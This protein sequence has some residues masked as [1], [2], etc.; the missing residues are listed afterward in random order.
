MHHVNDNEVVIPNQKYRKITSN[1]KKGILA[2]HS[3]INSDNCYINTEV[4]YKSKRN[5]YN[6]SKRTSN[7]LVHNSNSTMGNKKY[8]NN[9][10]K[11]N[12][13]CSQIKAAII[14]K[15]TYLRNT[16]NGNNNNICKKN[17]YLFLHLN[18]DNDLT[19]STA[20]SKRITN[21]NVQ[22]NK[23][24]SI[25]KSNIGE[26]DN[27]IKINSNLPVIKSLRRNF[28]Q[29]FYNSIDLFKNTS[30]HFHSKKRNKETKEYELRDN[31]AKS[32]EKHNNE[33]E[34]N[35][36]LSF[37]MN[38]SNISLTYSEDTETK[39]Y[40]YQR[41]ELKDEEVQEN[42]NSFYKNIHQKLFGLP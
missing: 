19:Q 38:N 13:N 20:T 30:F 2:I 37:L 11:D 3:N 8:T 33:S 42:F 1:I 6:H 34:N 39:R 9:K 15:T 32:S 27:L 12:L 31:E 21:N 40:F 35:K 5:D 25:Q 36:D 17:K 7:L 24:Q 26:E 4:N 18:N 16:T 41:N 22:N 23:H 10:G 14:N 29:K 28:R